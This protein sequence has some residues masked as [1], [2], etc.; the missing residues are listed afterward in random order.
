MP[1]PSFTVTGNLFEITGET[2]ASELVESA[3]TSLRFTF[4]PNLYNIND[5]I[6]YSGKLYKLDMI[7]AGVESDGNICN[8]TM[9]NGDVVPNGDPIQLL[10]EDAGLSV[11]GL[12]WKAQL[13]TLTINGWRELSSWWFDAYADGATVN[14][15]AVL[16]PGEGSIVEFVT[17]N[18]AD[19]IDIADSTAVGRA[20][21]TA[22]D[23]AAVQA[24]AAPTATAVKTAA[25][26]ASPGQLVLADATSGGFTVSLPAAPV[27][28]STIWVKKTD[29]TDNTV[30][31]QRTGTDTVGSAGS[32]SL[33][34]VLPSQLAVLSYRSGVWHVVSSGVAPASLDEKYAPLNAVYLLD[35]FGNRRVEFAATST[36]SNY[37]KLTGSAGAAAAPGIAA[38]NPTNSSQDVALRLSP[39][40]S[41]TIDLYCPSN[42]TI[43]Q[44]NGPGTNVSM[45]LNTKGSGK[46]Y[47]KGAGG[48]YA[49]VVDLSGSQALTNKNLTGTGN[50]FPTF[51]QNTTGTAAGLSSTLAVGSGGTGQTTAA[52]AITAL[53]GTQTSGR[54][55]RSDGT[56]ATLSAI[57]AAD[58][59]TLNQNTTG[60][61][62]SAATLTT[63]R[64]IDGTSFDG[65]A[66]ITVVAP[67]TV[68]AT[69]KTT[70]VD[71]DVLPLVDSAASN[72]LKKLS[73][74]NLV[75]TLKTYFDSV[76]TTLSSKT[77]SA[78]QF[79]GVSAVA[80]AGTVSWFN[81][82][83]QTT[84]YERI[85]AYWQ[86]N[87]FYLASE[88]GGTGT[89]RT[90]NVGSQLQVNAFG[91]AAIPSAGGTV[92]VPV[93]SSTAGVG[94]FGVYGTLSSSSGFQYS[95]S[96]LP[97]ISQT[98]TAGYTALLINPTE[99]T[100]G[101]GTKRLID[102][103]VGGTTKF[104]VSNT[105]AVSVSGTAAT[106]SSGTGSPESVVTAV[107][108]SLYTR[109]DG[110]AGTTLY[111]KESGAGNTGWVAK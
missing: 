107:V 75:A 82:A 6:S 81:T 37:L 46:V 76:T 78:A 67:G 89:R 44:A 2:L 20:L 33:Q 51:N 53:T 11:A 39:S 109:T 80:N 102:A 55:L 24:V 62:A 85:R 50:T 86:T 7:Y 26:S 52:A 72:V 13:E 94:Q 31:V 16:Q 97:S 27:A 84:N 10:A 58:V 49:E 3:P 91:T 22:A 104:N 28:G 34:L 87:I 45:Y 21:I 4:T 106:I 74:A 108:G 59:P 96:V 35:E 5:L 99:T 19:S 25:Y 101:S 48:S 42:Q 57:Q 92:A 64:T 29:T 54:Y 43:V 30:L 36:T 65:S 17:R 12:Q 73:W 41:G 18:A 68:A 93:N 100:T 105:G 61:S 1:L 56:N 40:G 110:G 66:N 23:A 98:S 111:V 88:S 15:A 70:P 79:T 38:A 47:A 90:I 95:T 103:Q 8:A 77:L 69:A 32:S 71:A 9:V 83:D 60:T 14:L 63:P